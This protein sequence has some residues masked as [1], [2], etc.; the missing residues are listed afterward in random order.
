[1][2]LKS[3]F[4]FVL[5]GIALWVFEINGVGL[6]LG[7]SAIVGAVFGYTFWATIKVLWIKKKQ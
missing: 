7:I 2:T 4:P 5:I 6:S 3:L 1:M